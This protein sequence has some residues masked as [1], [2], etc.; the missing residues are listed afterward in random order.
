MYDKPDQN[1]RRAEGK[2]VGVGHLNKVFW[3]Q[4]KKR[5]INSYILPFHF[6]NNLVF[7]GLKEENLCANNAEWMVKEVKEDLKIRLGFW[8]NISLCQTSFNSISVTRSNQRANKNLWYLIVIFQLLKNQLH[9]SRDIP[10]TKVKLFFLKGE[11]ENRL[12]PCARSN[13]TND[14]LLGDSWNRGGTWL[15]P[16]HCSIWEIHGSPNDTW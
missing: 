5:W 13:H 14:I 1:C 4:K 10:F 8:S 9:I 2:D 3:P 16:C 7:Y 15:P 11:Q 12:H 6:R